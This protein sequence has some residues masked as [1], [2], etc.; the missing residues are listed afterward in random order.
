M[1]ADPRILVDET[2]DKLEQLSGYLSEGTKAHARELTPEARIRK[3][4]LITLRILTSKLE[5]VRPT[6][7]SNT[8]QMELRECSICD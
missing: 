2:L 7:L 6:L 1:P 8:A 3:E 4:A 5:R